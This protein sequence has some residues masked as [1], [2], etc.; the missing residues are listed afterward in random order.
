[1]DA[2]ESKGQGKG[3]NRFGRRAQTP[4]EEAAWVVGRAK[5]NAFAKNVSPDEYPDD[6]DDPPQR[7]LGEQC[8]LMTEY[9]LDAVHWNLNMNHG[10]GKENATP[11]K[12]PHLVSIPF[13]RLENLEN[14]ETRY[15]ETCWH[16]QHILGG[17]IRAAN[18]DVPLRLEL[19]SHKANKIVTKHASHYWRECRSERVALQVIQKDQAMMHIYHA[20][21]S[22]QTARPSSNHG[23]HNAQHESSG[24]AVQ[25]F[26]RLP[27]KRR[28]HRRQVTHGT[29]ARRRRLRREDKECPRVPL[30]RKAADNTSKDFSS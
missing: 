1:M 15:T 17:I 19:R 9:L 29:L 12:W 11:P 13:W 2:G 10:E 28:P 26:P 27:V 5:V 24:N 6:Q 22:A 20:M 4:A 23:R 3:K 18:D 25:G 8:L 21:G 7:S 14:R 30:P 16:E